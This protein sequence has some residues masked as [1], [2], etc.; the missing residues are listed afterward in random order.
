M[1]NLGIGC[2]DTINL[3]YNPCKIDPPPKYVKEVGHEEENTGFLGHYI[4][5]CHNRTPM[6][7][8][9][10]SDIS[11]LKSGPLH[12]TDQP[13]C[14]NCR[15]KVKDG[16]INLVLRNYL[17]DRYNFSF[18]MLKQKHNVEIYTSQILI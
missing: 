15:A 8:V 17:V 18:E 12:F 2:S 10:N 13:Y 3:L 16:I 5:Y 11:S 6:F 9:L 4:A 1:S 7:A 14:K